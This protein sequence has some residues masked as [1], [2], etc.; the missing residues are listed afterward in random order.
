MKG[1]ECPV[2]SWDFIGCQFLLLFHV[3]KARC[4]FWS[5]GLSFHAALYRL[6]FENSA[7][8]PQFLRKLWAFQ[9]CTVIRGGHRS[10]LSGFKQKEIH[11]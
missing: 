11:S 7:L 1:P 9:H 10:H 8:S 5:L 4:A 6:P 3:F 2:G